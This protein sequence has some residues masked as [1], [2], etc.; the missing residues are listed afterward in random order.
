MRKM[1][2]VFQRDFTNPRRPVLLRDVTPGCE[3]VL[4]GEGVPTRKWDGT[5][6]MA[7]GGKIYARIDCK[8]GRAPPPGSIPCDPQPDPVTGHWP[9]WIEATR[10]GDTWI[11]TA[12]G[13]LLLPG[14]VPRWPDGTYEA[15]GPRINGNAEGLAEHTLVPHGGLYLSDVPRD[16]DGLRAWLA[17]HGCEGVVFRCSDGRMAKIRR[18]DFGLPWPAPEPIG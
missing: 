13:Q 15:V 10:P 4:A 5:A 1:P 14:G 2:C 9:H 7:R 18:D 16:F 11:R 12:A 17:G 3:W 6:A 8:A